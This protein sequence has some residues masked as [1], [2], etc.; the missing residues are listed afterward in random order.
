M[1]LTK[2]SHSKFCGCSSHLVCIV[3]NILITSAVHVL[4]EKSLCFSVVLNSDCDKVSG[5]S[6][7]SSVVPVLQANVF[8][9]WATT[10]SRVQFFQEFPLWSSL[11]VRFE[12]RYVLFISVN[13][14]CR[15]TLMFFMIRFYKYCVLRFRIGPIWY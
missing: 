10:W 7:N 8:M 12:K 4:T 3:R 6:Q 5:R 14:S 1:H 13:T 11:H 15:N 2:R 9:S